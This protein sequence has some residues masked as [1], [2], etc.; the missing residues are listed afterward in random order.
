MDWQPNVDGIRWFVADILPRIR[1]RLPSCRFMIA[2]RRT[3]PSIRKMAGDYP[4]IR[5]TGTVDDVRPYLW[6]SAVSVVPLRI[7]GGARLKIFEAMAARIPV[8]STAIGAEGLGFQMAATSG[9]PTPRRLRRLLPRGPHRPNRPLPH[10]VRGL[11]N[12]GRLLFLGS[13]FAKI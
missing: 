7:G 6:E 12:G 9:S 4:C 3:G 10:G 1:Q 11:G 13:S 8:V 2:G 5:V